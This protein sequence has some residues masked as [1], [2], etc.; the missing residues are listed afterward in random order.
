[1]KRLLF[2][3][4]ITLLTFAG[5]ALTASFWFVSRQ[6]VQ[7]ETEVPE[8][9]SVEAQIQE[10]QT[11]RVEKAAQDCYQ[12]GVDE[13][14]LG[15]RH[16]VRPRAQ[17]SNIIGQLAEFAELFGKSRINTFYISKVESDDDGNL[18]T[19]D[20]YVYAY[21]KENNIILILYPPFDVEDETTFNW[22]YDK[23]IDIKNDVVATEKEAGTSNYLV[24]RSFVNEL[25][26]KCVK[27]GIKVTIDKSNFKK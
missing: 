17:H 5:G 4:F 9:K 23:G 1:M 16:Y 8:I 26:D 6:S 20:E 15:I 27:R 3:F 10:S 18:Q 11:D 13:R 25:L 7:S 19:N 12:V 21:W 14:K 2:Y 22:Y 24:T